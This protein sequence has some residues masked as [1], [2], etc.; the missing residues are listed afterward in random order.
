MIPPQAG[1]PDLES[2]SYSPIFSFRQELRAPHF[3]PTL[4]ALI[5]LETIDQMNK[6]VRIVGYSAINFFIS[7]VTKKQ[8][9]MENET[10][11]FI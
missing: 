6:E 8:P 5:S 9:T 4:M 2:F 10:V 3:D 1:L 7:R 11:D